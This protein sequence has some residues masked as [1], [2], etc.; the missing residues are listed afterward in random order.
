MGS[1]ITSNVFLLGYAVGKKFL[2]LKEKFVLEAI[3]E[4]VPARA[5]DE[6][7]KAFEMGIKKK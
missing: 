4:V 5:L 2:P 6:N 7:V 3:K 1:V